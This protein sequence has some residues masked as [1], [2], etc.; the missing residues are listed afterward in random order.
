MVYSPSCVAVLSIAAAESMVV[1][2]LSCARERGEDPELLN[3][4]DLS[5]LA[6]C[7][8]TQLGPT[9]LQPTSMQVRGTAD[10]G[11]QLSFGACMPIN[12]SCCSIGALNCTHLYEAIFWGNVVPEQSCA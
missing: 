11:G 5:C 2:E 6:C 3:A 8:A 9:S 1:A 10:V 12:P 7:S 4:C